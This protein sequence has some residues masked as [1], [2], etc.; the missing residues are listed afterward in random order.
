MIVVDASAI[1]DVLLDLAPHSEGI[2]ERLAAES[3]DLAAPHLLD[4]EVAQVVRRYALA[5]EVGVARARAALDDLGALQITRYA[6]T[7]FLGRVFQLRDNATVYDALYLVLAETLG[8]PLL[9]RDSSLG[10]VPGHDA[11]VLVVT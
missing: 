8:A 10:R 6:H 4:A 2:A 9:T 7:P 1:V 5:G 3:P 11:E